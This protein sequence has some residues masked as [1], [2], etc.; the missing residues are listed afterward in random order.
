[1]GG[2]PCQIQ[3]TAGQLG[4]GWKGWEVTI[5]LDTKRDMNQFK[6]Y[7]HGTT[8]ISR[9]KFQRL[10]GVDHVNKIDQITVVHFKFVEDLCRFN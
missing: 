4:E 7:Y 2:S 9:S 8:A 3:E 1:M 5:G 6:C 10:E